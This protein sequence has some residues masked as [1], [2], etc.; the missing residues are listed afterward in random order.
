MLAV[1]WLTIAWLPL[2]CH[3][4][5]PEV[6]WDGGHLIPMESSLIRLVGEMVDV[7]L[8]GEGHPGGRVNVTYWLFNPVPQAMTINMTFLLHDDA[9]I[10]SS[11]ILRREYDFTVSIGDS[12]VPLRWAPAAVDNKWTEFGITASDT[13]PVWTIQIPGRTTLPI[14]MHYAVEATGG[15]DGVN[16]GFHFRYLTKSARL[17]AGT[18]EFAQFRVR[19]RL[20][21]DLLA[22]R[23][24][25]L[26]ECDS[27]LISPPGWF[28]DAGVLTWRFEDWEPDV[29]ISL[30]LSCVEATGVWSFISG[31][32]RQISYDAGDYRFVSFGKPGVPYA[33]ESQ[34]YVTEDILEQIRDAFTSLASARRRPGNYLPFA[35][36]FLTW[37]RNEMDA[38]QGRIY[39]DHALQYSYNRQG[40]Y[41]GDSTWTP[42][43]RS[44]V[45]RANRMLLSEL[46]ARIT[47]DPSVLLPLP[48]DGE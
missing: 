48:T 3:A 45:A 29:D 4:N 6:G 22:R 40:W 16:Y 32:G 8:E 2:P 15:A 26:S 17:W 12:L 20:L 39:I 21:P 36:A 14:E 47:R 11:A 43:R 24:P 34:S 5:G 19:T 33:G 28:V 42:A 7:T 30:D 23:N 37:R 25:V 13:L 41:R 27:A 9:F 18:I 31:E 35:V 38:R 44:P 46:E 10:G 1:T